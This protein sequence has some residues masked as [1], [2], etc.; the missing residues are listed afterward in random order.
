[1]GWRLYEISTITMVTD[2][3]GI[4]NFN[5]PLREAI[6]DGTELDF[7]RPRCTMKLVN[8]SAMDLNITTW[9]FS[10]ATVKFIESKYAV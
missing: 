2:T 6:L 10:L 3:I 1:M 8:S 5:P 9:P 4:I 7:D